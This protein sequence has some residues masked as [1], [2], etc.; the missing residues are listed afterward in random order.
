MIRATC[1]HCERILEFPDDRAGMEVRCAVCDQPLTV[2]GP[3]AEYVPEAI[4]LH[5]SLLFTAEQP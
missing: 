4:P 1:P 5:A 3:E 2:G